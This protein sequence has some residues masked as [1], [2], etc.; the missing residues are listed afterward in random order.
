MQTKAQQQREQRY[1]KQL[2]KCGFR[3]WAKANSRRFELIERQLSAQTNAAENTEVRQLQ[4]LLHYYLTWKT[5]DQ[6]GRNLRKADRILK[7][8]KK[9][10]AELSQ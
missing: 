1:R 7:Q 2:R 10:V 6:L 9:R 8:V 5:N 3:S 4:K